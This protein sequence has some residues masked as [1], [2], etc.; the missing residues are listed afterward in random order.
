MASSAATAR[1]E[2]PPL[3]FVVDPDFGMEGGVRTAASLEAILF[4]YD[5]QLSRWLAWDESRAS[6]KALGILG[7]TLK[8]FFI[9]TPIVALEAVFVHEVFGHGARAREWGLSPSY[10]FGV[11]FPYSL[12]F[13]GPDYYGRTAATTTGDLERDLQNNAAGIEA[14]YFDAWWINVRMMESGARLHYGEMLTYAVEKFTHVNVFAG[15]LSHLPANPN[16]VSDVDAYLSNLQL[17]FNRWRPGDRGPMQRNLR[18]AYL[19][20]Y[21]DPTLWLSIYHFLVTYGYKSER[22][23]QLP[24][25]RIGPVRLLPA[26]RF[27]LS[28]FGAENYLDIFANAIG[29]TF[30]FYLRVGTSGLARNWGIGLR[31]FELRIP[32]GF[33][34]GGELDVWDQPELVFGQRA[35]FD[36][37]NRFG[38]GLALHCN[39]QIWNRFGIVAKAAYKTRG[40]L[41]GEPLDQGFYG[42]AGLSIASEPSGA[43]LPRPPRR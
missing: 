19:W 15:D 11:V 4:Q 41:M 7:R 2:G 37:D 33:T 42:Y 18:I 31:A 14:Q 21:V 1:A 13:P 16:D 3:V 36:R 24:T 32:A 20:N 25:I 10:S 22:Y 8:S 29:A 6:R 27:N 28:P 38:I 34:V 35:V 43:L 9:D 30:D 40:Y 17:R 39:W 26:T 5:A 23:A 12:I